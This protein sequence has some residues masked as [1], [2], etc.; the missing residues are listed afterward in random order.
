M[1]IVSHIYPD[2]DSIGSM[3]GM[4]MFLT[5]K[6]LEVS[7]MVPNEIPV[8]L[9]WMQ[10]CDRIIIGEDD[11]GQAHR[12]ISN[13]DLIFC[14]DFNELDRLKN[15]QDDIQRSGALKIMIDHHPYPEEFADITLSFPGHSSTA[16]IIFDII[17]VI[18]PAGKLDK[19]IAECLFTGMMTD[20]G[21]FSFSSSEPETYLAVAELLRTGIDKD[22]I[23]NLVYENY[24]DTRMRLMGYSLDQKM[25]VVPELH[26]AYIALTM[27]DLEKYDHVTGDTEGFVNLPFSVRGIRV[28]ALFIER[29]DHVKISFRSRGNFAINQFAEKYFNGGGHKNAAGGESILPLDQTIKMF[30]ELLWKHENEL[31]S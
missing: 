14:L 6:G 9:H 10:G 26:A 8:F 20:T 21:C 17:R 2:G 13:A 27:E 28:T 23:F 30:I 24:S 31:T 11:A 29:T 16:E 12:V 15:F 5:G 19:F 7:M 4:Y 22:R 1:A 25:E 3:L 18:D